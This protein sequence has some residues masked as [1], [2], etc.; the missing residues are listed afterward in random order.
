MRIN[1]LIAAVPLL[2]LAALTACGGGKSSTTTTTTQSQTAASP[3]ATAAGGSMTSAQANA[4]QAPIP[5]SLHCGAVAP[6]WVNTKRHTYHTANDP[7]YGKTKNGQYMCAS[8]AV[9]AGYH[10]AGSRGTRGHHRKGGS[11]SG[12]MQAQPEPS[13]T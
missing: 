9:A 10:L 3:A 12:S 8:A 5:A 13:P 7:Y 6:V 1:R 4:V 2:A 11:M